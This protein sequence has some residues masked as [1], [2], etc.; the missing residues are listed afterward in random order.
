MSMWDTVSIPL[1]VRQSID[2]I[3]GGILLGGIDRNNEAN[4]EILTSKLRVRKYTAAKFLGTFQSNIFNNVFAVFYDIVIKLGTSVFSVE[5]IEAIIDNNRD[6]VLDTPFIN[7][8]DFIGGDRNIPSDDDIINAMISALKSEYVRLSYKYVSEE[9]FD[10]AC[11]IYID[12]YKDTFM[13]YVCNNMTIIMSNTGLDLKMTS[14]RS[15]HYQGRKDAE[16]YYTESMAILNSIDKNGG[17]RVT[18]LDEQWY[19]QTTEKSKETDDKAIMTLGISEIDNVWK[20]LRRG[21]M[22]G[23]LG[24]TKGGK[25]RFCHYL[26]ARAIRKK[27]N[28]F[29]MIME[30]NS[31]EWSSAITSSLIADLSYNDVKRRGS[32]SILRLSSADIMRNVYR[33]KPKISGIINKVRQDMAI[34]PNLGRIEIMEGPQN[35]ETLQDVIKAQYKKS[36]FDVIIIDSLVNVK[37]TSIKDKSTAIST[38]Y[39]DTK[40]TIEYGLPRPVLAFCTAQLKQTT[41]DELRR[42]P[43]SDMEVT[44]GGESAE[45]I[46]TPDFTLGLFSSKEELKADIMKMFSVAQRHSQAF[47]NFSC[48][49]YM[50]C[51]Y[52]MSEDDDISN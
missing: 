3:F 17:V 15:R 8:A 45:T 28:V 39:M 46:R 25:T 34:S 1:G 30:G 52:F 23:I 2:T 38:A 22:V 35:V 47:D 7:K 43:D 16:E 36:P 31:E 49:G 10:S 24:K 12:W 44:A 50:D 4:K 9:E 51:C 33:N 14:K 26:A 13:F 29:I 41:I 19:R 42:N 21:Q 5:Q 40:Q 32:G 27:L 20:E 18:A 11:T 48:R 37:S 6:I